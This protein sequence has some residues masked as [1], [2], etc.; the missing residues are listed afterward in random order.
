MNVKLDATQVVRAY[1]GVLNELRKMTGFSQMDVLR[2]EAGIILKT[3]AG[4][5]KV[6]RRQDIELRTRRRAIRLIGASRAGAASDYTTINSGIRGEEGRIWFRTKNQKFQL[7]GHVGLGT[8]RV[9]FANIHLRRDDWNGVVDTVNRVREMYKKILP[10]AEQSA[11]LARQSWVQIADS[12]GINLLAVRGGGTLSAAGIAKA[13]AAI[14][15]TGVAYTN[16]ASTAGGDAERAHVT[17]INRLP[18]GSKAATEMGRGFD[19]MVIQILNGRTKYFEQSY[20]KGAFDS[21]LATARAFPWVKIT[22]TAG[23]GG[24]SDN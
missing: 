16:G 18:Y 2:G 6:A 8:G 13:R 15:S 19:P 9:Q 11:G 23:Q 21:I 17:L 14:A 3:A 10:Q 1:S 20:A 12:L 4:R 22:S 24:F 5:T 7:M